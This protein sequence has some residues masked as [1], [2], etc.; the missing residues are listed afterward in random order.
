MNLKAAPPLVLTEEQ[1]DEFVQGI[2]EIVEVVDS[3][4]AFWTEALG[5]ARRAVNI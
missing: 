4:P 1:L 2:R 5:L 3:S